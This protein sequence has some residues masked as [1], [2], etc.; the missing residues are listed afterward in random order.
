MGVGAKSAVD[1]GRGIGFRMVGC[2]GEPPIAFP[3]KV[4]EGSSHLL[5]SQ[6]HF[7]LVP[8]RPRLTL[9]PLDALKI[10]IDHIGVRVVDRRGDQ[11]GGQRQRCGRSGLWGTT[12]G[13]SQ[14]EWRGAGGG[15]NPGVLGPPFGRL[16]LVVNRRT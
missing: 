10:L 11:S 8:L 13:R 7:L 14:R 15:P 5:D 4:P 6:L 1:V 16:D 2:E 3:F 12:V 9:R